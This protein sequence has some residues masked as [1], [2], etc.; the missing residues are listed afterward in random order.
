[1]APARPDFSPSKGVPPMASFDNLVYG[2]WM[3][4]I[5][6]VHG[7]PV[8]TSEPLALSRLTAPGPAE[9]R[10]GNCAFE[11]VRIQSRTCSL[12]ARKIFSSGS[13]PIG[14]NGR[15]ITCGDAR[16]PGAGNAKR[17]LT[18][19]LFAW[20]GQRLNK[21]LFTRNVQLGKSRAAPKRLLAT[22]T[23]VLKFVF[24]VPGRHR[25]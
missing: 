24:N 16:S 9:D 2:C 11:F 19:N 1:L 20:I 23:D 17:V 5:L 18:S 14:S 4:P 22:P 25:A 6:P 12:R 7:L 10:P 13:R 21:T 3:Q 8:G 15:R